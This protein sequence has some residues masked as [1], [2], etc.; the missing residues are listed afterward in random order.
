MNTKSAVGSGFAHPTVLAAVLLT[1][2]LTVQLMSSFAQAAMTLQTVA[3]VLITGPRQTNEYSGTTPDG[4]YNGCSASLQVRDGKLSGGL[5]YGDSGAYVEAA[6]TSQVLGTKNGEVITLNFTSD[7]QADT[8][9]TLTVQSRKVLAMTVTIH[10]KIL[11]IPHT[12]TL[13]CEA[14]TQF[15]PRY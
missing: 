10:D 2:H 13:T 8:D 12:K 7:A 11:F 4:N 6:L 1:V 9:L 14:L 15:I 3:D 5:S